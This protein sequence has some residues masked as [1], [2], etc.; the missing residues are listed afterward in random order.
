MRLCEICIDRPVFA[1]VLSFALIIF[2][3]IGF[4]N[5]D[6]QYFPTV[7]L[8]IAKVSVTYDGASPSLMKNEVTQKLENALVNVRG[9]NY[10]SSRS[11]Y[12]RSTVN[13]TFDD[14]TNM[15]RAMGDVRNKISEIRG[16]LPTDID[17][18]SISEGGVATPVLN[19]GFLDA[20]LS[21][22][23]IR[24]Y[25][26]QNIQPLLQNLPGMGAIWLYGAGN[27]AMRIWL[28]PQK[29]AALNVTVTD[30][31]DALTSNNINFSGGSIQGADRRYSLVAD[32]KFS[33]VKQFKQMILRA[34]NG[35][36]V[37][38]ADVA[39]IEL[40]S[41][42][43]T[44]SPMRTNGVN[45]IDMEVRPLRS[46]NPISVATEAKQV[47][48]KVKLP[49]GMK[50]VITYDQSDY[51]KAAISESFETL[52]LAVVLVMLVVFLFLG[53]LRGALIPIITIPVCIISVFGVI[54]MCGYSV[55]V[56]TL[57]AI[58]LAI[59]LVVD[60]AIVVLE[61]IHR[62]LEKG[63]SRLQAAKMGSREIGFSVIA[64]TLTL[65]AVYAPSGFA[66]GFS[67]KVFQEFAF[68]LAGA[69]L[70]SG[71][72]ALT[73][74]PMMCA[75]VLR[76]HGQSSR[77]EKIV[78][79]VFV[80]INRRFK[81]FLSKVLDKR[82][83]IALILILIG[84]L[85][86]GIFKMVPQSFIPKE[87]IGFFQINITSPP[88][89]T[90]SYTDG[91]MKKF[92]KVYAKTPGI[93]NYLSF[94][95][96]GSAVN[97]IITKP[98]Q[99]RTHTSEQIMNKTL[100]KISQ[101]PG[102]IVKGDLPD[103]VSYGNGSGGQAVQIKIMSATGS[104]LQIEKT[105]EKVERVL[106]NYPGLRGI[107]SNLKFD[108]QVYQIHFKRNAAAT[109]GVPLQNVADT[110]SIMMS[111]R[112]ITDIER[113]NQNYDVKVQMQA[114]D[115]ANLSSLSKLYVRSTLLDKKGNPVLVPLSNLI[116]LNS[117]VRQNTLHRYNRQDA[118]TISASLAPGYSIGEVVDHLNQV[119]PGLVPEGQTFT[120][121]GRI[122][123]FL[124][125][126]GVMLSLFFLSVIFIYLVLSAQFE[127]F[128]DPFIILLTV[129]FCIVG[130]LL[131]LWLAGGSI[132][133]YTQ[134]GLITLVGLIT[135]HGILIT[136]FANVRLKQGEALIEAVL[137]ATTTRLRPILMTTFAMVLGAV[138][139]ALATGPGAN[140][141]SQIGWVIVGGMLFG[142]FF[143][144]VVVPVAYVYL[145]RFD[146]KKKVLLVCQSQ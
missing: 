76:E 118:A 136:Q 49:K 2:G 105:I 22:A 77:L 7:D 126:S 128:I 91:F 57:L 26:T 8:P 1:S 90:V 53:S 71:F 25:V 38:L 94:I 21:P 97:F 4:K 138:P 132:N 133:L 20:Q 93:E 101:I 120:Y 98:W 99:V 96:A 60:D 11:Q 106:H 82:L 123:S 104:Y 78:D 109:Y 88:G 50:M 110:L 115:L 54:W 27:Y 142:T 23:K 17:A 14:G 89:S 59:G 74:T 19:V 42:S 129:P 32:T 61:N 122:L 13:L 145:A 66:N 51:L 102:V 86:Y 65:A 84:L 67:A 112:H 121:S 72:V 55:N 10:M 75:K 139:L 41:S 31:S 144:L 108:N 45:S 103:P 28:N 37:R 46:A 100:A 16:Q 141:H 124:K 137:N 9:L 43:F 81:R 125:S 44:P 131:T 140:S 85:G 114:K 18:P 107:D 119:L 87:D 63:L 111:G 79:R 35:N 24:S 116:S 58:I 80:V 52:L 48:A 3:L 30:V 12:N 62:H 34:T 73:L 83:S 64:M 29:M 95:N 134:I 47:L 33:D 113:H 15:I 146:H 70:I 36:I 6:T 92:E 143:S 39:R 69:V 127:S 5:V 56:M 135:K 117:A 130:A 40:G 68:T